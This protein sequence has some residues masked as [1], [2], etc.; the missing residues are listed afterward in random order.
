M[1]MKAGKLYF[2]K[3][4][5]TATGLSTGVYDLLRQMRAAGV[6]VGKPTGVKT[7]TGDI[8]VYSD[9]DLAA[10]LAWKESHLPNKAKVKQPPKSTGRPVGRPRKEKPPE[11]PN[12]YASTPAEQRYYELLAEAP[13]LRDEAYFE[14]LEALEAERA[15][16]TP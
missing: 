2:I 11:P 14:A 3:D 7:G 6:K 9:D 1:A 15:T 8:M 13:K 4:I 10:I 5:K 12:P 16:R